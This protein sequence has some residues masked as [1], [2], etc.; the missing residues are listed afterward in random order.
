MNK[1]VAALAAIYIIC[2]I[3][4]FGHAFATTDTYVNSLDGKTYKADPP[5]K[6]LHGGVAGLFWPLYLSAKAW[7]AARPGEPI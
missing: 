3:V 7:E 1:F 4:A 6:V 5:F 2:G